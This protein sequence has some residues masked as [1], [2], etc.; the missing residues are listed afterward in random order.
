M[1]AATVCAAGC[2][3]ST[4]PPVP[5]A[6]PVP[7]QASAPRTRGLDAADLDTVCL[8]CRD[9]F[10]YANGGWL[11]RATIPAAYPAW[12]SFDE[13]RDRNEA[14]LHRLLDAAAAETS[15][16]AESA[17]RKLGLF[18]A[19][20]MDSARADA[21]GARPLE[22]ELDRIERV[23]SRADLVAEIARL[24][25][26]AVPVLFGL[27]ADQDAKH[28]T[29]II[30]I[31]SQGGLGLPDRDYYTRTD[32][33]SERLRQEYVEHQAR[34]LGLLGEPVATAREDSRAVLTI[35]TALARA[36]MTRVELR[37]PNATYHKMT[38][39]ELDALAPVFAWGEYF[40]G[41]A[42]ATID[43][44]NVAQ[45]RFFQ[46]VNRLLVDV[47][48]PEWRAYLR[49][50]LVSAS[51]PWLGA[52][53]AAE[54]F[55][56][57]QTLVGVKEQLPRWK[58]CLAR[59][60]GSLGDA[61]GRAYVAETFSPEAKARALAMVEQLKAVLRDR[62]TSLE[63]MS[64]ATRRQALAK[65]DA[66]ETKI[67]Y[68]DVWRDY[69][70]LVIERGPFLVN[71]RRAAEFEH[72][73]RMAMI[74]GPVDRTEWQMTPPT[75]NAYYTPTMNEIVFPA[76][77]LQP[78]FFD[79]DADD[80]V[81][82]GGMGAVIGHEMTHGFDDRG[83]QYDADGNLRDWWTPEDGQRFQARARLVER[84]FAGYIAVDSIHVN[85]KLTLGENIADLGGVKIAYAALEHSLAGKRVPPKIAGFTAEQR[86]FLAWARIW[87]GKRRPEY[88]RL[89]AT[90]DSH[91]PGPWR[92]N[93]PLADIPEFARAFGCRSGDPMVQPDSVR[94]QI[95]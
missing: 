36:S 60:D 47:P 45:P 76:G 80:A 67:G 62:L 29:Q 42:S 11:A 71:L 94:A 22:A 2:S 93:G 83:R 21:D 49:V 31:V 70:A 69:S 12:G 30:A 92:A 39:G 52:R 55:R 72:A 82:Y 16:S 61:L 32:T 56:F 19:T 3:H 48:L 88:A 17:T 85:G 15:A 33:A 58:R 20:C 46:E 54:N 77:I 87:R 4:V 8:P 41:A 66:F 26:A 14:V 28:S 9:F 25:R 90:T 59:A 89:L 79:P 40:R 50:R 81:N 51:A 10:L 44:L 63:W 23:A 91:S 5:P 34:L 18:Y 37:D 74:G 68:P 65:L 27:R 64:G 73:R 78:P 75:V 38:V 24:H 35:E 86:F 57:R 84:Q 6:S 1:S 7:T 95:W 53:F 13:L 43:T